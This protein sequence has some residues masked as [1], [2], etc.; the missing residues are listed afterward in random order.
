M[1]AQDKSPRNRK[2]VADMSIFR[3]RIFYWGY[4]KTALCL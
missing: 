4:N 3:E 2:L 1:N